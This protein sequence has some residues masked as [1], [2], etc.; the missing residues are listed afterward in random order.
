MSDRSSG[1]RARGHKLAPMLKSRTAQIQRKTAQNPEARLEVRYA[2]DGIPGCCWGSLGGAGRER[3]HLCGRFQWKVLATRTLRAITAASAHTLMAICLTFLSEK[4][5]I[6]CRLRISAR[7]GCRHVPGLS[8][9]GSVVDF[10]GVVTAVLATEEDMFVWTLFGICLDVLVFLETVRI[11][12]GG[13][14]V[15]MCI[16]PIYY[17]PTEGE[18][19]V[20]NIRG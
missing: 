3:T 2:L 7:R 11:C 17:S 5:T 12:S 10:L 4:V 9:T 16:I 19:T 15:W 6:S 14:R 1:L 13:L 18:P 8:W 20:S